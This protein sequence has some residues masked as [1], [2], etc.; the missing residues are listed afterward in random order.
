MTNH[1]RDVVVDI[2]TLVALF[3]DYLSEEDMPRDAVAV[4]LMLH[5]TERKLAI[6]AESEGWAHGLA[7]LEVRFDIRRIFGV[8]G[9]A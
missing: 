4:K 8:G 9:H 1:V 3:K 5:P 6:V 7:P 2:D